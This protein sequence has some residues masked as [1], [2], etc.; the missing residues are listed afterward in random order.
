V[1]HQRACHGPKHV[2]GGECRGKGAC[3]R[4]CEEGGWARGLLQL[5]SWQQI[6]GVYSRRIWPRR[7]P[8]SARTSHRSMMIC[9]S[10]RAD[11]YICHAV[12]AQASSDRQTSPVRASLE[13][14]ADGRKC[15]IARMFLAL[16]SAWLRFFALFSP[17]KQGREGCDGA[18]FAGSV[19][20][21][22]ST[23]QTELACVEA[24]FPCH[25]ACQGK[26]FP[27][28]RSL[29]TAPLGDQPFGRYGT[30][31]NEPSSARCPFCGFS[32]PAGKIRESVADGRLD[33]RAWSG[34]RL[35]ART[36][37]G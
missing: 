23:R 29:V 28:R 30:I 19:G 8:A 15:L 4:A 14:P 11:F 9:H 31:A 5:P 35:S 32:L 6:W 13:R 27:C 12:R 1:L 2:A 21:I 7:G 16:R 36:Y 25:P 20:V 37:E 22:G 17:V 33:G 34:G 26:N 24:E 3:S 10:L 18:L